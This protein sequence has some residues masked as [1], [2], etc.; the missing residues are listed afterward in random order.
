MSLPVT[1]PYVFGNVTSSIPLTNLD[2]DFATIY[3]AVNGIGNGT[4]AL[5]NVTITGGTIT[6]VSETATS[7]VATKVIS[8]SS[9]VGAYS[10]GVLSYPDVNI[11]ESFTASANT[12][13]QNVLQNTN[14]GTTASVD[15]VVSNNL[16]T[17]TTYY[18]D[19]GMN[20]SGW[21]GTAGTNSFNAPNMVYL[22]ATSADLAIGT[23]GSNAIHFVVN[24]AAD[25]MTIN[26]SGY[27]GIGTASPTY[28]LTINSSS[29]VDV[30]TGTI[31]TAGTSRF[32]TRASG[33]AFAGG[34]TASTSFEL[35]SA[36]S[37]NGTLDSNGNLGIGV[38]P[39]T[40]STGKVVEVG[41]VGNAL[42]NAGSADLYLACNVYYNGAYKYASNGYA[43]YYEQVGGLHRWNIAP[44]GT[45][46]AT[47]TF[48]QAM[49]LNNSG[50]L[51]LGNTNPQNPVSI[52]SSS[53][54]NASIIS[55]AD[56]G[57][58]NSLGVLVTYATG[59][60]QSNPRAV[61]G[62]SGYAGY[63]KLY[64]SGNTLRTTLSTTGLTFNNASALTNSTLNDY[65]TGTWTP[66]ALSGLTVVGTFSS[67]GNYTKIGRMVY[68][69]GYV[70]GS[71]SV[72]AAAAATFVG[73]LPFGAITSP[74]Q[75]G[76]GIVGATNSGGFVLAYSTT[77]Y[78]VSAFSTTNYYFNIAYQ[79]SF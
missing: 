47:A 8:T 26:T 79:T 30:Q 58:G 7:Y 73:G 41:S 10:Y 33:N 48:T 62:M 42:W 31:N 50:Y 66:T 77:I 25:A 67:G 71:V 64:D 74:Q 72:S 16:G 24:S 44:S 69:S 49:T 37:L 55:S 60:P 19:Y 20:G 75:P 57:S 68:L 5:A 45:A 76:V 46:G 3:A 34:F 15:Y 29:A 61:L 53:S 12:Y 27:V 78:A 52:F 2:A 39:S 43:S 70:S 14:S 6:N 32:G 56:D 63:V 4:V 1:P 18:G 59:S 28:Q 13:V 54:S 35:W 51:G 38:I 36:G 40:W 65:E 22:S 9:N 17:A 21:T 11:F 23:T